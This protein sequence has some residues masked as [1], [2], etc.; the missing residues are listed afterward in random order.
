MTEKIA[1]LKSTCSTKNFVFPNKMSSRITYS[2][3]E[4]DLLL[5]FNENVLDF[6][7]SIVSQA[8]KTKVMMFYYCNLSHQAEFGRYFDFGK[9]SLEVYGF[10]VWKKISTFF[11]VLYLRW[12]HFS[13]S[14]QTPLMTLLYPG[15]RLSSKTYV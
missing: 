11:Y 5:N 6:D 7:S 9:L 15:I 3:S 2:R 4:L 1:K 10:F 14:S 13:A 12:S 8:A